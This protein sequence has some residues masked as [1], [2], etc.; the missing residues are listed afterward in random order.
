MNAKELSARLAAAGSKEDKIALLDSHAGKLME[1]GKH[2]EALRSYTK[3]LEMEKQSNARAYFT[4]QIGICHFHLGN[5]KKALAHLL[6][7]ARMFQPDK[8]EFMPDMYGF[9]HFHLG[10]LYEYHGKLS[11]SLEARRVCEQYIDSQEKD[12]QWMLFAGIS[13]IY[14][15]LG[16]HDDS[17]RY[18]QKAIQVLSDNDPGLAYLYESMGNNYMSLGQYRE[19]IKYLAKVTELDPN[20][21]R[22]DEIYIKIAECYQRLT[23]DKLAL[24]SYQKILEL[25]QISGRRENLTWL[26]LKLAHCYF[27]LEQFEK[28][29][30]VTLE[31]LRRQS[32]SKQ[33]RAE[34]RSMLTCNYYEMGRYSEAVLEG[35]RT[36]RAARRF[37]NDSVFYFRMAMSYHKLGDRKSF[38]KYRAFCKKHFPGDGWNKY[39]DKLTGL[40]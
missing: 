37:P 23:N 12:T 26:Y 27:R 22:R 40:P 21:E 30:L 33:E 1:Q 6:R 10:S 3:A 2:R 15:A 17:I 35:E 28:S 4:G 11:K 29:L 38:A 36:I 31:A 18:S 25:K 16:R 19:A 14:E 32:R 20:F 5:D 9:V 7:S 34:V 8:P 13:R 24:E 39:L